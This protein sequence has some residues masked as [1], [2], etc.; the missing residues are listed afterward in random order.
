[1][2][3]NYFKTAWRNL[4]RNKGFAFTNIV[5]LTIGLTATMLILLWVESE[6]SW[7]KFQKNYDYTYQ[8]YANRN[9]NGTI[10]TDFSIM[11]PLADAVKQ[12]LPEVENAVFTSYGEDHILTVDDK[13]F[14]LNGYRVSKHFFDIFSYRSLQGNLSDALSV[15]DAFVITKSTAIALFNTVDAINKTIRLD[16]RTDVKVTAVIEDVPDNATQT[17]AFVM[18]YTYGDAEMSNWTNAFSTVYVQ[19]KKN[20]SHPQ[21]EAKLNALVKRRSSNVNASY[22]LHPMSKWRLYG[23]FRDGKNVGGMITY[24]KLFVVI[25]VVILLIGCINFMN[26]ST[27]QSE[28]RAREVGI[29]KTLGSARNQLM[30][31]FFSESILLSF[32]AFILSLGVAYLVLPFFNELIERELNLP[33]F[34]PYFWVFAFGVILL[35]GIVAGS[36]P[37]IYL[38]S[39]NPVK[40]LKG[41]FLPGKASVA[42]RRVL[43]VAQFVISILLISATVIVYQQI[44]HVKHRDLGYDANNLLTLASSPD[45]SRNIDV[46]RNELTQAGVIATMTQT[47][48]PV[49][50]IYNY[51]PAPDYEGKPDGQMIVSSMRVGPDFTRTMGIKMKEG[52][53][54]TNG[55]ADT[56][57]MLLNEAAVKTMG[58]NKPVGTIMRYGG[59]DYV[60]QGVTHNVVM[61]SPYLPVDPMIIFY[62]PTVSGT[63]TIRLNEHTPPQKAI[64]AIEKVIST[65]NPSQPFEYRFVDAEFNRKF[66]TEELIGTLTNLFAG[67]AILICSIGMAGLAAYSIERRIREISVRKVLGATAAQLLMLIASEFLKLV[68][69]AFL[70]AVPLT[71]WLMSNWLQ[72]YE[73][74]VTIQGWIFALV[75]AVVFMVTLSIVWLNVFKTLSA[76]PAQKLRAD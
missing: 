25:A 63:V 62:R 19:V 20:H 33:I 59:R 70:I 30:M 37:A 21:L 11:L 60:V 5:S 61:A 6:L 66:L 40:V 42:P 32:L 45:I 4:L 28:K 65:Y 58:L 67:L 24:V 47:S 10:N 34:N 27:A 9:F 8:V 29:R 16:N 56:A 55:P 38:S 53:D 68:A 26:L 50:A 76:N 44:Q 31:Q 72:N 13:K 51:T 57:A 43:V 74:R 64:A 48:S 14:R 18:P 15:P 23:E 71:W 49:T 46:I 35:T 12:E 41:T 7:D 52:R 54:F 73:Y 22:H 36:Y 17:F 3:R 39:F 1:M 69:I 2:L 75:G